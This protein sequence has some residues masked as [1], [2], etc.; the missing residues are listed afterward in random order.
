MFDAF[1]LRERLGQ[2]G[3]AEG[4][5]VGLQVLVVLVE[6]D[7]EHLVVK[8]EGLVA[9]LVSRRRDQIL[10]ARHMQKL[11]HEF[12]DQL[13][14]VRGLGLVNERRQFGRCLVQ[15]VN[16]IA[17]RRRVRARFLSAAA[18]EAEQ[19]EQQDEPPSL[20]I[21]HAPHLSFPALS[22]SSSARPPARACCSRYT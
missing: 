14:L 15:I 13:V 9:R 3:R 20:F 16:R 21:R 4:L 8:T 7:I 5:P 17:P 1:D 6:V 2:C 12:A 22:G 10:G 11:L 19:A 18:A